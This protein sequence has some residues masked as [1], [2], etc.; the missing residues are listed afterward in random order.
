MEFLFI[1]WLL[2]SLDFPGIWGFLFNFHIY[3]FLWVFTVLGKWPNTGDSMSKIPVLVWV[4]LRTDL[5]TRLWVQKS[6]GG[7]GR[8]ERKG[9]R[10]TE[11]C[12]SVVTAVTAGPWKSL[13]GPLR[14]CAKHM[15]N[16]W[17]T[18]G[19]LATSCHSYSFIGCRMLLGTSAP[20]HFPQAG[21]QET[22]RASWGTEVISREV[23]QGLWPQHVLQCNFCPQGTHPAVSRGVSRIHGTVGQW[24][25]V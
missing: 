19:S 14:D 8:W 12:A 16:G 24:E 7:V 20:W 6:W 18:L 25:G 5:E 22:P 11:G 3:P 10:L 9:G 21:S 13:C 17:W 1:F 4:P 2:L 15:Q 23:G